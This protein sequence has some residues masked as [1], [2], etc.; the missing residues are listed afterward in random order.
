MF[1]DIIMNKEHS[2][3]PYYWQLSPKCKMDGEQ[4]ILDML[5][6]E[7][8][9]FTSSGIKYTMNIN[10]DRYWEFYTGFK[11]IRS[12]IQKLLSSG[13]I[14]AVESWW[15]NFFKTFNVAYCIPSFVDSTQWKSNY[16]NRDCME[17][18]IRKYFY[19]KESEYG[20]DI[21]GKF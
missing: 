11:N 20:I 21:S 4:I 18:Y 7:K 8:K 10:L 3:I 19:Q 9:P 17:D 2:N 13:K 15:P 5:S 12:T 1:S 16:K 14:K 6:T